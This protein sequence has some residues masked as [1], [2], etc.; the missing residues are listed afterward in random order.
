MKSRLF[1]ILF[2]V[3]LFWS[4]FGAESEQLKLVLKVFPHE[5]D[6]Y[7]DNQL[8]YPSFNFNNIKEYS[9]P[10]GTDMLFLR[11]MGYR[12]KYIFSDE[13]SDP[14]PIEIKMERVVTSLVYRDMLNTDSQPKSVEFSEDGK[15][16]AVALLNGGGVEIYSLE[17]MILFR[18]LKPPVEWSEKK[19]FVETVFFKTRNELW[20]SQMTTG[21]I[22]VFNTANWKYERSFNCGGSWPKV[23]ILNK[24]EDKAYISNWASKNISIIDTV[25]YKVK[26]TISVNGIP[27]GISILQIKNLFMLLI[28]HPGILIKLILEKR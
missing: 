1:V 2:L 23:I 3:A 20:V 11:S 16:L 12:D 22:H 8:F 13:F 4:V 27:R 18:T 28:L 9:I 21:L 7:I 26:G 25:N 15:Y 10:F 17:D 5:Y 6:L 19:G 14:D 24:N